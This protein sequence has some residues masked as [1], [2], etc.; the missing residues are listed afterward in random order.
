MKAFILANLI[1]VL[2]TI[3]GLSIG[4]MEAN[5]FIRLIMHSAGVP[6][7][8]MVKL[9]LALGVGLL[10]NRWR[11]RVLTVLTGIFA[12]V[13]INNSFVVLTYFQ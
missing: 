11:P 2:S 7:A 10:L 4:A 12:L 1:D 8:L 3:S 6:E 5:P 13:A 9:A